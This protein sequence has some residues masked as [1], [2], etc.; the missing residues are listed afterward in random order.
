MSRALEPD[1]SAFTALP[2]A[3]PAAAALFNPCDPATLSDGQLGERL[4][5]FSTQIACLTAQFLDIL[6]E[7]DHRGAWGGDGILSCA[8]WLS[9]RTGMSIR[10]AHDHLRV[11]RSL[12]TLPAIKEAFTAGRLSY[13][14]VRAITRVATSARE[15]ELLGIALSADAAQLE[16]V[17]RS[18]RT[19][20]QRLAGDTTTSN[21]DSDVQ[22]PPPF[23]STA[24]WTW[25]F[26]GT[27]SVT[28]HLN[29][30]DGAS[31]LAATV[32]AEYERT[33]TAADSDITLPDA[34]PPSA[35]PPSA[36]STYDPDRPT[37]NNRLWK[38]T[39]SNI[40]PAVVAM[41][42]TV[43][44]T[45][46]VPAFTPGA[47]VVIHTYRHT[48]AK[49]ESDDTVETPG[50][51]TT[52]DPHL[53]A[54][55]AL[56]GIDVDEASCC[57]SRRHVEHHD[58]HRTRGHRGSSR[59]AGRP[60]PVTGW[61][62]KTR[63]PNARILATLLARDG[64]C[65]YPGCGRTRHLH[66]HHV[67]FW[68]RGGTTT[69]DNMI[70]L[71]SAHHRALHRGE[72]SI[73]AHDVEHF[74]FHRGSDGGLIAEAPPLTQPDGWTPADVS[75]DTITPISPGKLDLGYTT[76]VLYAVWEFTR[77]RAQQL[78]AEAEPTEAA[79]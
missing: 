51:A 38:H 7:F 70:L 47:D 9:L 57:G 59:P 64:G 33:R 1:T 19:I 11:A 40:A 74:T 50:G 54:G 53:D 52:T 79:A 71:C 20:D 62:R 75:A 32:R 18:I 37:D 36:A 73:T 14:K 35:E 61:G 17:V 39:P 49:S 58:E 34:E 30:L 3:D 5:G 2:S 26:D 12:R 68:S 42:E 67:A 55:P 56:S 43:H 27:L 25:N 46:D 29:S 66:A 63:V 4:I 15:H 60:A 77:R 72:F 65:R 45:I 10:T 21:A 6:G 31:F 78:R 69:T 28:M 16:R 8:H 48:M 13:S 24:S 22:T 41:A 23:E 76:E 44:H